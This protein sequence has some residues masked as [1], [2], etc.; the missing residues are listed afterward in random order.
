MALLRGDVKARLRQADGHR[1]GGIGGEGDMRGERAELIVA[2]ARQLLVAPR[3]RGKP[4]VPD[5]CRGR[6]DGDGGGVPLL[7]IL[8]HA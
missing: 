4:S 8:Y 6:A 7:S 3:L 1:R 5:D 2:R